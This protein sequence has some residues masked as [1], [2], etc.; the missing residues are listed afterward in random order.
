MLE[1]KVHSK[2]KDFAHFQDNPNWIHQLTMGRMVARGIRLKSSTIIQTGINHD[3][4]YF[5]Y[6]IPALL[7]PDSLLIIVSERMVNKLI[8]EQ[9]PLVKQHLNSEKEI[10]NSYPQNHENFSFNNRENILYIIDFKT[11]FKYSFT[12]N[13]AQI[14]HKLTTVIVNAEEL[15]DSINQYLTITLSYSNLAQIISDLNSVKKDLLREKLANLLQ[16]I[17]N[18]PSNPDDSYLLENNEIKLIKEILLEINNLE[19]ESNLYGFLESLSEL[20][21]YIHYFIIDRKKGS[22]YLKATPLELKSAIKN[23]W[24]EQDLIIIAN[25]LEPEKK[26]LDFGHYL[27]LDLDKFICLKFS[28]NPQSKILNLYFPSGF[29]FPNNPHFATRVNREILA[30]ISS[31]KINHNPIIVIID[32][33]P[34]QGQI[35]AN[36][37]AN[38]GTRVKLKTIEVEDN[39][40]LVCDTNF[41]LKNQEILPFPKLLIMPTLPLPSLENPLISAKVTYFKSKKKDWFRLYLL[42][43]AIKNLQQITFSL[44]QNQGV[45]ALLDNRVNYRSYGRKILLALEP[46]GKIN[47]VDLDWIN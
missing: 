33:V 44:R 17:Y 7:S 29:P 35:S 11:W 31:I 5:S 32:D 34:L 42:P 6:L 39:N 36:L 18:H 28:P 4:Y 40:I 1:A 21:K 16:S 43:I 2:L 45:L 38:F 26:P 25:Y 14:N 19:N 9:I 24:Q 20:E 12:D 27:G 30:L 47:Y 3:Q 10:V 41:Y 37:A 46:Y 8:D 23:K 15:I 13:Y 22:F